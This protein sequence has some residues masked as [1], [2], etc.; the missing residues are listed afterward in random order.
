VPDA[1]GLARVHVTGA[2]TYLSVPLGDGAFFCIKPLVPVQ[3]A[4]VLSC[5]GGIDLGVS[6]TQDHH[7]GAL[8]VDGF[9]ADDCS[10]AGGSIESDEQPHPGVCNGPVEVGASPQADSGAGALLIAADARFGSQGLPVEISLGG[11][12]CETHGFGQS[13]VLGL[14]SALSRAT[15]LDANDVDGDIFQRDVSGENFSCPAWMQENGPGRLVLAV[16]A[17]H[18]IR[19]R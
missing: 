15:I 13:T 19:L 2:S 5:T 16:P 18:G 6:S 3:N 12:P 1:N 11:G 9:T 7:L 4:G 14:V 8:A 10:D 17:L